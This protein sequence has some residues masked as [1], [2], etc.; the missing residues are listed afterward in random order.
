[1]NAGCNDILFAILFILA[2]IFSVAVGIYAFSTGD[3][4]QLK[5]IA[6]VDNSTVKE[7]FAEWLS[8][9]VAHLKGDGSVLIGTGIFALVLAFIWLELLKRFTRFFIYVTMALGVLASLVVGIYWLATGV[10]DSNTTFQVGGGVAL[11]ASVLLLCLVLFLRKRIDLTAALFR[12]T[13]LALQQTPSL[14][15]TTCVYGA[16]VIAAVAWFGSTWVYLYSIPSDTPNKFNTSI[17]NLMLAVVFCFFWSLAFVNGALQ[18]TIG[19]AVSKHY[20]NNAKVGSQIGNHPFVAL[21]RCFTTSLGSLALGSVLIAFVQFLNYLLEKSKQNANKA[22]AKP[23]VWALSCVQCCLGSIESLIKFIT[24][25][26]FIWI[27]MYNESFFKAGKNV[28]AT[29]KSNTFSAVLVDSIGN[30]VIFIGVLAGTALT[31]LFAYMLLDTSDKHAPSFLTVG[32]ACVLGYS[33]FRLFGSLL[34]TG[35]DTVFV[36]Y[37]HDCDLN[38]GNAAQMH[39]SEELRDMLANRRTLQRNGGSG[40][41]QSN[42]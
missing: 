9:C 42:A 20:F 40:D 1:M 6:H 8:N 26:V 4:S 13:T 23:V 27:G 29:V 7:T 2:S 11:G 32:I 12:Q 16:L 10:R 22:G 28:W 24:K 35:S 38:G 41:A 36:S 33:I 17:R 15:L 30:F 37:M 14:L 34:S 19:A 18:M 5:V 31:A 21:V 25:F 39:L 3:P